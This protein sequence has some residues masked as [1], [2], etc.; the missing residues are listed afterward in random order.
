MKRQ[1]VT[2]LQQYQA[3]RMSEAEL[4]REYAR[5]R[6]DE[7]AQA[8]THDERLAAGAVPCRRVMVDGPGSIDDM[9]VVETWLAPL[10]VARCWST[11]WRSR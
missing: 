10:A 1:I 3:G 9:R 7:G 6:E 11:R 5:L 2:L 8:A 4:K